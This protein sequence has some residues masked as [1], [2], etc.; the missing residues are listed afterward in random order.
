MTVTANATSAAY[1]LNMAT[2][3]SKRVDV[4]DRIAENA[5]RDR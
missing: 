2:S 4:R 1:L 5:R 3:R